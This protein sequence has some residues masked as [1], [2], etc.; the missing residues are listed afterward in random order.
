MAARQRRGDVRQHHGGAGAGQRTAVRLGGSGNPT[1][2]RG[3]WH[4]ATATS[5]IALSV[6]S[7]GA[8]P[9]LAGWSPPRLREDLT[10]PTSR[11][12]RL[13]YFLQRLAS[14]PTASSGAEA[15]TQLDTTL[16]A[17]E[18]EF[19]GVPFDP[20]SWM[21]DG[22]MYP[23]QDDFSFPVAGHPEVT[24][25]RSRKHRIYIRTNGAVRIETTT[26]A[27]LLDKPGADGQ[28]VFDTSTETGQ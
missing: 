22:R 12:L 23:P 7:A 3:A 15:R 18:D 13:T 2:A 27:P 28:R 20:S 26:R 8:G 10:L 25:F 11:S 16:N 24:L 9:A 6:G 17:V 5:R 14:I 19:S 1:P 21:M 4:G